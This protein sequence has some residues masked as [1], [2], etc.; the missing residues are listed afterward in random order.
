MTDS[1]TIWLQHLPCHW[2]QGSFGWSDW[3]DGLLL[4]PS[5]LCVPLL[6]THSQ[7]KR[8]VFPIEGSAL[9]SRTSKKLFSSSRTPHKL[10]GCTWLHHYFLG[11]T[12]KFFLTYRILYFSAINTWVLK[13]RKEE[14]LKR[15]RE[16]GRSHNLR[17]HKTLGYSKD[18]L[19]NMLI[20]L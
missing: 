20:F 3:L 2:S 7:E 13:R 1:R 15:E 4:H 11:C 5:P 16:R 18:L 12:Q 9:Q 8:T 6:K 17:K 14:R 19:Y 10:S